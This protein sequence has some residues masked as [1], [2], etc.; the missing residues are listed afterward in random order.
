[1]KKGSL[2]L[3][4][5]V[6]FLCFNAGYTQDYNPLPFVVTL[7]NQEAIL[8]EDNVTVAVISDPVPNDAEIIVDNDS[9]MVIINV[10]PTDGEGNATPGTQPLVILIQDGNKTTLDKTVDNKTLESGNYVMNIVVSG[11]TARV[12]FTVE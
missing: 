8:S 7:G 1:M 10:F 5:V 6:A 2:I 9:G 11:K 3:L 4:F 12:L